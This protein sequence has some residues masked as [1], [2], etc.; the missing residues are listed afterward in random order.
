MK[1]PSLLNS[2]WFL[3]EV[4]VKDTGLETKMSAY[5]FLLKV[6]QGKITDIQTAS[7]T[8]TIHSN[9]VDGEDFVFLSESLP[10]LWH[11]LVSSCCT[12]SASYSHLA[13]RVWVTVISLKILFQ[14]C[15]TSEKKT[16]QLL[17]DINYRGLY[18]QCVLRLSIRHLCV[19]EDYDLTQN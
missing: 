11:F 6:T 14:E 19:N 2:V 9:T 13:G 16:V 4:H 3:L 15:N 12:R 8:R 10:I 1:F 18:S 5:P 7:P 17:S